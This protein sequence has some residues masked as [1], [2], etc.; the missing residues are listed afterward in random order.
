MR[1]ARKNI[2]AANKRPTL[3]A[4]KRCSAIR[5]HPTIDFNLP[6]GS[7]PRS[8]PYATMARALPRWIYSNNSALQRRVGHSRQGQGQRRSLQ[9]A[10][11]DWPYN[12][13]AWAGPASTSYT[14]H[15]VL[16]RLQGVAGPRR[17]LRPTEEYT[18]KVTP[19]STRLDPA[20]CSSLRTSQN[21][22]GESAQPHLDCNVVSSSSGSANFPQLGI[23]PHLTE[24]GLAARVVLVI[25]IVVRSAVTLSQ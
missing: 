7:Q 13:V 15:S 4:S 18:S 24:K 12:A 21:P 2:S 6:F 3:A 5:Q 23:H 16:F 8:R 17:I 11:G 22:R 1:P 19:Y 10:S 9:C 14:R 20:R 25:V